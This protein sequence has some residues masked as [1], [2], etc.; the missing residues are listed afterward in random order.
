MLPSPARRTFLAAAL[1]LLLAAP[2][3][4]SA[5]E[6]PKPATLSLSGSAEVTAAPDMAVITSGVVTEAKTARAALTANNAAMADV[7][8]AMKEAGIAAKDLQTSGFSVEPQYFH[9]PQQRDGTRE[10]P[11]ITGYK[12]SNRLTVKVRDLDRLGRLLDLSVSL[13]ANQVSG[14]DFA[15]TDE[16]PLRDEARRQAMADAL[17]KAR[18]YAEAAGVTLKRVLTITESSGRRPPQPV[19]F[20]AMAMEASDRVPVEAGELALTAE[21][22]VTWEIE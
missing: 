14:V 11:R 19:A 8:A 4:A 16:Q 18:L 9:P 1:A 10:P 15:V 3:A 17:R 5:Q 2:L 7:A 22:D 12:V 21:V 13:G 20:R 6:E